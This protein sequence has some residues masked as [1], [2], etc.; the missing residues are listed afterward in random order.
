MACSAVTVLLLARRMYDTLTPLF[1]S[2][3][4][5]RE[6]RGCNRHYNLEEDCKDEA[7]CEQ[8]GQFT[9]AHCVVNTMD[10]GFPDQPAR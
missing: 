8:Y 4:E 6:A 5:G 7:D 3:E 9:E 2:L 1:T 10:Q